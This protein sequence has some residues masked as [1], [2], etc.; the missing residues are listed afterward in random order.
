[1]KNI[2]ETLRA[3]AHSP[4]SQLVALLE[5][6]QLVETLSGPGPFTV[7]AP[8]NQAF[9]RVPKEV[10]QALLSDADALKKVLL[11]HVVAGYA[12]SA[13]D[14][15][16]RP[17]QLKTASDEPTW[18]WRCSESGAVYNMDARVT[19]ANIRAQN[20]IVHIVDRVIVPPSIARTLLPMPT[21]VAPITNRVPNTSSQL[22]VASVAEKAKPL[23]TLFT[24]LKKAKL[25]DALN[26][27]GPFTV[28]APTNNAFAELP[29]RLVDHLL[30]NEKLL[31]RVLLYHVI[32]D[33]IIA[34][35]D[36]PERSSAWSTMNGEPIWVSRCPGEDQIHVMDALVLPKVHD[37]LV[38]NGMVHLVDK[39][40]LPPDL[41]RNVDSWL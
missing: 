41:M 20:G 37:I 38:S 33:V 16:A 8:T 28:F 29:K 30:R 9:D 32:A 31:Q 4:M 7:F 13:G 14:V 40:L 22:T 23:S 5:R 24:V 1:M 2:V 3:V 25:T 34:G 10:L 19:A 15:P 12:T 27:K 17:T 35:D 39:V 26:G 21:Y 6:A 11:F 18:A 36:V